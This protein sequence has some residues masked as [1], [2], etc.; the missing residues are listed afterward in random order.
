M[1]ENKTSQTTISITKALW[2]P[3]SVFKD[4]RGKDRPFVG[5]AIEKIENALEFNL[6]ADFLKTKPVYEG[7][8]TEPFLKLSCGR[9]WTNVR[10]GHEIAY[11][12]LKEIRD[13]AKVVKE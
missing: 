2:S 8:Q 4:Y 12:P 7:I 5:V 6:K 9:G 1:Q 13:L 11:L 10:G 3:K